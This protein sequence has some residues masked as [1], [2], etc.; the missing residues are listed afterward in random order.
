VSAE[1]RKPVMAFVLLAVAAIGVV[2]LQRADA[3]PGRFLA[4]AV[5]VHA[6]AQGTLHLSS[7]AL[8][9]VAREHAAAM[10]PLFEVLVTAP[11][12]GHD[13][14]LGAAA[15]Q[16]VTTGPQAASPGEPDVRQTQQAANS[17]GGGSQVS[18]AHVA[19]DS[20]DALA[21]RSL[22]TSTSP[23]TREFDGDRTV[24]R[25]VAEA[26]RTAREVVETV[27]GRVAAT[28]REQAPRPG[29][30]RS[31]ERAER[32][33]RW[34]AKREARAERRAERVDRWMAKREARAE[35]RAERVDRWVAKREARAERRAERVDRWMAKHEARSERLT[36]WLS[37]RGD[38]HSRGPG[39]G[40]SRGHGHGRGD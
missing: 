35:R 29:E 34:V 17:A 6:Q 11:H 3:Q 21:E 22:A 7:P 15:A 36:E 13:G 30:R 38:S 18:A 27:A 12:G 28:A 37:D 14:R 26:A 23:R 20:T 33:D 9:H 8:T 25:V 31:E 16:A 39:H 5:G 24:R 4:A 40:D 32:L 2:G 1:H 10:G 19:G